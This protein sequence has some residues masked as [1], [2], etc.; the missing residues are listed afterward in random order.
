ME[1][2]QRRGLGDLVN[3]IVGPIY[4]GSGEREEMR[5]KFRT[6]AINYEDALT[7]YNFCGRS[8]VEQYDSILL[9]YTHDSLIGSF[10][11]DLFDTDGVDSFGFHGHDIMIF[12]RI[13]RNT[14]RDHP[15]WKQKTLD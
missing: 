6:Q 12:Y 8:W 13:I 3:P 5:G 9:H 10:V 15:R 7:H 11:D 14:S 4:L 2:G 1:D